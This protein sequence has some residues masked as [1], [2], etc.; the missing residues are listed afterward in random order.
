MQQAL[1]CPKHLESLTDLPHLHAPDIY[2][3][4]V[5]HL[6]ICIARQPCKPTVT[7]HTEACPKNVIWRDSCDSNIIE[8]SLNKQ[9]A[10]DIPGP[11][12]AAPDRSV[13][14][15]AAA[16]SLVRLEVDRSAA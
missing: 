12:I 14:L 1:P 15:P 3:L 11:L 6:L 2:R 16:C 10:L 5:H 13:R 4:A 8:F 9:A 7:R